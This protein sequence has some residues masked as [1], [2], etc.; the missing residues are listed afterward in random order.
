[1][2]DH[3]DEISFIEVF[4]SLWKSRVIIAVITCVFLFVSIIIANFV[5]PKKYVS[6]SY[7]RVSVEGGLVNYAQTLNSEVTLKRIIDKLQLNSN[8]YTVESLRDSIQLSTDENSN[9]MKIEVEGKNANIITKIA[10]QLAYELG[11]RIEISDRSEMIVESQRKLLDLD[12]QILVQMK[13]LESAQKEL[14]TTPEYLVTRKSLTED[15]LLRDITGEKYNL[16]IGDAAAIQY[17]EEQP[18]PVYFSLKTMVSEGNVNLAKLKEQKNN[19]LAKIEEHQNVVNDIE[20]SINEDIISSE[21]LERML[22]G[23]TA[24]F[25]SSAITPEEPSSPNKLIFVVILTIVGLVL[26][27]LVALSRKILDNSKHF[28]ITEQNKSITN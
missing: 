15:A 13:E 26:G 25:I 28:L 1:M 2:P 19:I 11:S 21:K 7:V 3:T 20:N 4:V 12:S 17:V 27:V 10:N 9:V 22:T 24:V 8:I 5:L 18:N 16:T 6:T 14:E 23:F